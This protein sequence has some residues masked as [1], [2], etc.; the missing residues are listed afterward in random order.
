MSRVPRPLP[1]SLVVRRS[2]RTTTITWMARDE[3]PSAAR[4]QRALRA[5]NRRRRRDEGPPF[6]TPSPRVYMPNRSLVYR[7][8]SNHPEMCRW[9]VASR[10]LGRHE[11]H[12]C[13][14]ITFN[15]ISFSSR[16]T[17][18]RPLDVAANKK[19]LRRSSSF[20]LLLLLSLLLLRGLRGGV[21]I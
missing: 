7:P 14:F 4:R 18:P 1:T 5:L 15:G 19:L 11:R 8:Q 16:T 12:F 9:F 2:S 6:P 3:A 20:L 21:L 17:V 13:A 10:E